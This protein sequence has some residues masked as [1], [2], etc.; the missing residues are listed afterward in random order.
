MMSTKYLL[1]F[2]LS[3]G[4]T[5]Q[6]Q[7][8]SSDSEKDAVRAVVTTMFEGM[9]LGDSAMVS[10]L[11]RPDA[12]FFSV[13]MT[14]QGQ[15]KVRKGSVRG[16]LDAIGTPHDEVWNEE[17]WDPVI[18]VERNFAHVWTP[19]A[20]YLDD[21]LSHCGVDSFHMMKDN[22]GQWKIFHATDTRKKSGCDEMIPDDIKAKHQK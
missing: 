17:W 10:K 22:D 15:S 9:M 4:L 13:Y 8:Q 21:E 14:P 7:G 18:Q 16:W 11:F 1:F 20:F 2:C 5:L 19:Y 3:M 12:E 6:I